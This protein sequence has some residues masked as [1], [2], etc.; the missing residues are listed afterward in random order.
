MSYV[1]KFI[2]QY[3]VTNLVWI[4]ML[5]KPTAHFLNKFGRFDEPTELLLLQLNLLVSANSSDFSSVE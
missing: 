4:V 1:H 3:I 5:F 2:F